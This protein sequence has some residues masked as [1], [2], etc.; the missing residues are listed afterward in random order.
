[1]NVSEWRDDREV[2]ILMQNLKPETINEELQSF[3]QV[4]VEDFRDEVL[5]HAGCDHVNAEVGGKFLAKWLAS[6][7]V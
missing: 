5:E 2:C 6:G 1:M 3:L 4:V 7:P